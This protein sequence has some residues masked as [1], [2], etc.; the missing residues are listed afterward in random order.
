MNTKTLARMTVAMVWIASL[1]IAR[2]SSAQEARLRLPVESESSLSPVDSSSESPVVVKEGSHVIKISGKITVLDAHTLQYADGT[3]VELNGG[4]D[5]PDIGQPALLGDALYPWGKQAAE[6]LKTAIGGRVVMCYVEGRSGSK[7][8]RGATFV[9]ETLLEI[10]MVR[11]GWA[12]SH[13]T[14]LDGW[15][16]IASD[17]RRGIWRGKFLEPERWRKGDRLPGEPEETESERAPLAAL[18]TLAPKVGYDESKAGK[19][20]ISLHFRPNADRKP[21]DD[22]LRHLSS[23]YNLR[24]LDL[25][26]AS[27]VSDAGLAHLMDLRELVELNVNWTNVTAAGVYALV[28]GRRMMTR[29]EVGGVD[30]HDGDL[31]LL[32]GLPYLHTLSLRATQVTD[33]GLEHLA[34]LDQLRT[35]NLM[36]TKITDAGLARL[37]KLTS[38]EN[39]DL[40][41]TAITDAGLVHLAPLVKLQSLQFA[42][43]GVTDAGLEHLKDLTGLKRLHVRGTK[44]TP[45][46][47]EKLQQQIPGLR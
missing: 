2:F 20:V 37:R 25:P 24:S 10:E 26:S 16:M 5:A 42:H 29:L 11:N 47:V 17:N 36:C 1:P 41:R 21:Q 18:Q 3:L 8:L 13:H 46:G 15:Q 9:G 6:F 19:P 22:D 34:G 31:A 12:V 23:F 33:E 39:L 43:T 7:K 32:K 27:S 35:L 44:V 40:D 30:F 38:L 4:M 28:R 45:Q 14:A